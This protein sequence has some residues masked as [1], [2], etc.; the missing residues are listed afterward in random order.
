SRRR[1]FEQVRSRTRNHWPRRPR[2]LST[3][4]Q[5][6]AQRKL[7]GQSTAACGKSANRA[8]MLRYPN[9]ASLASFRLRSDMPW[10]E[11]LGKEASVTSLQSRCRGVRRHFS[12]PRFVG[13]YAETRGIGS[14]R[15]RPTCTWCDG[16][17]PHRMVKFYDTI[18]QRRTRSPAFGPECRRHGRVLQGLSRCLLDLPRGSGGMAPESPD[19]ELLRPIW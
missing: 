18:L 15:P 14:A 19:R 17:H 8:E 5:Q 16:L 13:H 7:K 4:E 12:L 6:P 1:C 2:S 10:Q 9:H 11:R 3:N